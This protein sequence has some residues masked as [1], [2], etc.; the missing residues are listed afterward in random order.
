MLDDPFRPGRNGLYGLEQRIECHSP[1][2]LVILM[3]GSNDFQAMHEHSAEHTAQGMAMLISAVRNAPIE[4]GLP[5]PTVLVVAPPPI[6]TP[7]GTMASKFAGGAEK[8]AG[9]TAAY[10]QVCAA[11]DCHF[12]DAASVV[13]ASVVDGVHLDLDQ[14]AT[15]ADA[16]VGCGRG[17]AGYKLAKLLNCAARRRDTSTAS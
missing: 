15:L 14:H 11:M 2:A 3:F 4:P 6:S 9:L 7:Q 10:Q 16:L 13:T 17:A 8:C 1:L 12:F 5:A